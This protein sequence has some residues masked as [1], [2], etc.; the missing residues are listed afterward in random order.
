VQLWI[1]TGIV[2][3]VI[4][5]FMLAGMILIGTY[6]LWQLKDPWL[7]TLMLVLLSEFIGIAVV[8]YSNPIMGQFPTSTIVFISSMLFTSAHRWARKPVPSVDDSLL[9]RVPSYPVHGAF[10]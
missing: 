8:S 10:R 3:V 5:L 7:T 6:R 4:Y 9:H 2:G 1:E